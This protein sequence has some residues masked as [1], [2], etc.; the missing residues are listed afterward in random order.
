MPLAHLLLLAFLL[1]APAIQQ[2]AAPEAQIVPQRDGPFVYVALGDSSVEGVG[3]SSPERTY[4]SLLHGWLRDLYPEAS[5][6]N[7]GIGGAT[8]ADVL[9]DQAPAAIALEPHLI[10]LSVGPNDLTRGVPVELFEANVAAIFEALTRDTAAT[11]VVNLLPE[12]ALAPVI[13]EAQ[14]PLVAALTI[15][16]NQ[17]LER[18]ARQYNVEVVDLYSRSQAEGLPPELLSADRYHPSDAG[19]AVWAE[20]IWTGIAARLP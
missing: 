2:V 12:I 11:V 20:V 17:A 18:A 19:Y 5:L 14:K 4:P 16:F 10:T 7:L 6:A 3:A 8:S 1:L 9:R 13:P 15:Q